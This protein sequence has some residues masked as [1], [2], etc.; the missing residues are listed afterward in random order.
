VLRIK[1][2]IPRVKPLYFLL[3]EETKKYS[4][5][6]GFKINYERCPC[7]EMVF[8]RDVGRVLDKF[9]EKYE[10]CKN[11][12]VNSFLEVLPLLKDKYGKGEIKLCKKCKEPCSLDVCKTCEILGKM[13]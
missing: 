6:K 9:E 12:I 2:F 5:L 1:E 7:S 8:R 3:E 4:K 13:E 11:G 10:G